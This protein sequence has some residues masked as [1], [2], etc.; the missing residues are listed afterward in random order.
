MNDIPFFS[1]SQVREAVSPERALA[2]FLTPLESPGGQP[3]R[4]EVGAPADLCL[5]DAPLSAVLEDPSSTHVAA[6]IHGGV[7]R[8]H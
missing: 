7:P 8:V 4:V 6:T 5:L 2:L 3:R 1:G